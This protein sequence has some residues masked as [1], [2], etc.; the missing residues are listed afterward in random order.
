MDK[1]L[2]WIPGGAGDDRGTAS[3]PSRPLGVMVRGGPL[4][5]KA[6]YEGHLEIVHFLLENE[7]NMNVLSSSGVNTTPLYEGKRGRYER[8]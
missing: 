2:H 6:A 1:E 8:R 5:H 7:A 4:L 3:R